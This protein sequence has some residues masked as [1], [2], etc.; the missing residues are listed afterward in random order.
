MSDPLLAGFA[1]VDITPALDDPP[2]FEIFDP[3]Y[4]R[5]LH[6]RQGARRVTFLAADLFVLD[7]AM[8]ASAARRLAA[9]GVEA[10][11]VLPGASHIGT[12]PTLFSYYHNQP[13]EAL[14][15][16]GRDEDYAGAAAGVIE[17][18][19]RDAVPARLALGAGTAEAGLQ[20]N[21]RAHDDEGRLRM[22][23]L[24]EFPTPPE[25]LRYDAV[26]RQVGVLRVDREGRR[27]AALVAF[28]C[29]ALALWDDRG[30]ISGDYPGRMSRELAAAGIDSLFFQGALGNVHPVRREQDPAARI[31]RSLAATVQK[32]WSTLEPG[33]ADLDLRSATVGLEPAATAGVE[34]A[35]AEWESRPSEAEGLAR[36]DYWRARHFEGKGA[37]P[38]TLSSVRVGGGVLLHVPGEPFVETA[39]AIR[40]AVPADP[41]VVL[42]NPCPEVGYLPTPEAHQEGGDEPLFAALGA[43]E[44]PRLRR[45][46]IELL[47]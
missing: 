11:W 38:V 27:P 3:I 31:G 14:K 6:L 29:H 16:F 37:Q 46:A 22:V 32:V 17:A 5:A 43:G 9:A 44:E 45:A 12:G 36:Y 4:L 47:S 21:R 26:D 41:L 24:T 25:E 35:K 20:Y 7:E 13:T 34:A 19:C 33:A 8:L 30:N 1:R 28:G 18:A 42:S 39:E 2:S 40:A 15:E 23:S 10:G